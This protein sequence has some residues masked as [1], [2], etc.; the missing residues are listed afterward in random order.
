MNCRC[1]ILVFSVLQRLSKSRGQDQMVESNRAGLVRKK[2]R[3][4]QAVC[5]YIKLCLFITVL[6][7][8]T[9]KPAL[10]ISI[11]LWKLMNLRQNWKRCSQSA[12][13]HG[14]KSVALFDL[15]APAMKLLLLPTGDATA[16]LT[17]F[18]LKCSLIYLRWGDFQFC[19]IFVT[20]GLSGN[21]AIFISSWFW[22]WRL[23]F[24]TISEVLWFHT[25]AEV[26]EKLWNVPFPCF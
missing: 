22:T 16:E 13:Q 24:D 10:G 17:E 2:G 1:N 19:H 21:F 6:L 18:M 26:F 8:V 5:T 23:H 11:L 20:S 12:F 14:G 7:W 4:N 25:T 15:P 3:S 9:V